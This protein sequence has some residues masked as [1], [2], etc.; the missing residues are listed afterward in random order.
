MVT[1]VWQGLN[2]VGVSP[3]IVA[4][5]FCAT[6]EPSPTAGQPAIPTPEQPRQ[7]VSDG[8]S[9]R[10]EANEAHNP[11]CTI[12]FAAPL[13]QGFQRVTPQYSHNRI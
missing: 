7:D 8:W 4:L 13:L 11:A 1:H 10:P 3:P 9:S 6:S 2:R 12:T 5:V